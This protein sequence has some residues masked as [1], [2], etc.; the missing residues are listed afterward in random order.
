M[1]GSSHANDNTNNGISVV[2]WDEDGLP[3]QG[4][5]PF[6][7]T[8]PPRYLVAQLGSF[9][10]SIDNHIN[11]QYATLDLGNS[12]QTILQVEECRGCNCTVID[13]NITDCC[14]LSPN[15]SSCQSL[16]WP[17]RPTSY[18]QTSQYR[19]QPAGTPC[20][21]ATYEPLVSYYSI[22]DPYLKCVQCFGNR[23]HSRVYVPAEADHLAIV[24]DIHNAH[25]YHHHP[26]LKFPSNF[27]FGALVQ[28][29]PPKD[30]IWS[31][32]GIGYNS[33]FLQQLNITSFYFHLRVQSHIHKRS[34]NYIIFNPTKKQYPKTMVV[35][36]T[37][38]NESKR[39]FTLLGFTF[40]HNHDNSGVYSSTSFY[41]DSGN[42][43]I[44][45]N[46][47]A[48]YEQLA[49]ST[50]GKWRPP[51]DEEEYETLYVP[52]R[53]YNAPSLRVWL[54]LDVFVEI[55]GTSWVLYNNGTTIFST[56]TKNVLGLPF[57][58]SSDFL[59]DDTNQLLYITP[60]DTMASTTAKHY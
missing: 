19:T 55:P 13:E 12:G 17:S 29:M 56:Y 51:D 35:P 37:V 53:P 27:S 41:I 22:F 11:T 39:L 46:D 59:F 42:S 16:C 43:G 60:D 34:K 7:I 54:A 8:K 20:F 24:D 6:K 44:S 49:V 26:Q 25:H 30:R 33:S 9:H 50:S 47:T 1:G 57:L 3:A 4:Y 28:T 45:I 52:F 38:T 31:N 23:D 15:P 5:D 40:A 32:I 14:T 36:F 48:I 58:S 10:N 2:L 18:L 21:S